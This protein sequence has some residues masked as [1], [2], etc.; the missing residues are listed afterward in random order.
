ML[1]IFKKKVIVE[2]ENRDSMLNIRVPSRI[3]KHWIKVARSQNKTLSDL[4]NEKLYV[5]K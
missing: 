5:G 1:N 4:I 2:K 3:K